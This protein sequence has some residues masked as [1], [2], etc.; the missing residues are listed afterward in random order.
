MFTKKRVIADAGHFSSE[1]A[2]VVLRFFQLF[3]GDQATAEALTI[4]T[5]AEHVRNSGV[6][7]DGDVVVPLLR[8]ALTKGV[9]SAPLNP[10]S[11]DPLVLAI[12][13][14]EPMRRAV[15]VLFRGLSLDLDVV[16][17]ITGQDRIHARRTCAEALEELHQR[18]SSAAP[19]LRPASSN[20]SDTWEA[21]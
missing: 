19:T 10:R 13:R 1:W 17:K 8:R 2:P 16:A 5:L 11:T 3:V 14:V 15:I 7:S 18:L 9:A 6:D 12:T 20:P 4:D 21:K